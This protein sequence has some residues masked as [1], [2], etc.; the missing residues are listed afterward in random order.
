MNIATL[1]ARHARDRPA[2]LAPAT[3]GELTSNAA[4]PRLERV[5]R[6]PHWAGRAKQI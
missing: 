6:A 4:G 3:E 1:R 5:L 2:H